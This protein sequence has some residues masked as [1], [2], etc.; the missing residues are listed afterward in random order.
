MRY[1]S[2]QSDDIYLWPSAEAEGEHNSTN[3]VA[4]I[5]DLAAIA[6]STRPFVIDWSDW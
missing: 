5:E 4:H 3:A 2:A 1:A 6:V